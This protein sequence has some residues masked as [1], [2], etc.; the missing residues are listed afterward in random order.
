MPFETDDE[1]ISR[2]TNLDLSIYQ[3]KFGDAPYNYT[4]HCIYFYYVRIN[5]DGGLAVDHYL[6]GH[7]AKGEYTKDHTKWTEIK[8][9]EVSALTRKLA[10]NARP[11]P[12]GKNPKKLKSRN[13]EEILWTRRSHIVFF[14]DEKKWSFHTKADQ[15]PAVLFKKDEPGCS[16]NHAFFDGED[17]KI[18]MEKGDF[19]SA[20]RFIN[21]MTKNA[22]GELLGSNGKKE[23]LDY[24]MDFLLRVAFA[25]PGKENKLLTVIFDPPGGNQGPPEQP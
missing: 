14:F 18:E 21:H 17:M 9:S 1:V 2:I 12:K 4:P 10:F 15:I 25:K 20:V 11:Y 23:R 6:Y 3:E 16:P 24:K 13:F 7:D 22:K 8:P 19:R 5:K